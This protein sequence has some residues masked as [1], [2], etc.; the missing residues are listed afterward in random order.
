MF[1]L[2]SK[3]LKGFWGHGRLKLFPF[4]LLWLLALAVAYAAACI[5]VWKIA[6]DMVVLYA[7]CCVTLWLVYLAGCCQ[8][9]KH[10]QERPFNAGSANSALTIT[11]GLLVLTYTDGDRCHRIDANRST[12][13]VFVCAAGGE[14]EPTSSVGRPHFVNE[15]ECTYKFTWP[16]SLACQHTV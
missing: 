8:Q 5:T 4:P 9:E 13:I 12:V 7:L 3:F 1:Q 10:G 11:N 2:L 15:D 6:A 14:A 16:T